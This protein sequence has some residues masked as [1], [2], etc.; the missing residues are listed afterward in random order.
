MQ[1]A[2][3]FIGQIQ[4]QVA[5]RQLFEC[6]DGNLARSTGRITGIGR[7]L[8]L[9]VG[10]IYWI[11]LLVSIALIAGA[12]PG[13]SV[14]GSGLAIGL[15]LSLLVVLHRLGR[16]YVE[17]EFGRSPLV[18]DPSSAGTRLSW[19]E[20]VVIGLGG[21]DNIYVFLLLAG[22]AL[23]LQVEVLY[24]VA[25]HVTGVFVFV[26]VELVREVWSR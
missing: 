19:R 18:V 17:L 13:T 16:T 23:G 15:A 25:V 24:G 11:A 26:M 5:R 9:L 20:R 6:V 12:A 2:R 7:L 4:G 1:D 14:T 22:G 3:E 8:S 10:Q 21:L